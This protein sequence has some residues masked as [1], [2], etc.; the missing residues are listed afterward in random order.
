MP[1]RPSWLA[2]EHRW[3]RYYKE[4]PPTARSEA[5]RDRDRVLYS[6]AFLRLSGITQVASTEIGAT[7]HSRLTHSLKVAQ[8]ARR[9]AESLKANTSGGRPGRLARILDV[10]AVEA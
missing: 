9:L 10:D 4:R 2:E 7:F 8:V 3:A 5:A 1:P 6:S